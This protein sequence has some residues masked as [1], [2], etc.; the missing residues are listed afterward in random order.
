MPILSTHADRA[1]P[2]PTP[3]QVL[4]HQIDALTRVGVH[5]TDVHCDIA[6]GAEALSHPRRRTTRAR[7]WLL[8]LEQGIHTS[9]PPRTGRWLAILAEFQRD[10]IVALT[11]DGLAAVRGRG[12]KGGW[13]PSPYP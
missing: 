2:V 10:L 12:R 3:D 11:R 8:V 9:P 5:R 6:S 1:R 13:R 4:G 7:D